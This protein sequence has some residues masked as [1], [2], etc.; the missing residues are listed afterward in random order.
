MDFHFNISYNQETCTIVLTRHDNTTFTIDLPIE[1]TVKNGHYDANT[2][3]LVLVLV[4]NQEIRIPAS[5]LI[6]DYAGV[7]TAT[8]QLTISADNKISANII[9]GSIT[10][11]L[12]TTELQAELNDKVGSE[13]FN[14]E[15]SKKLNTAD[16]EE[17]TYEITYEDGTTETVRSV[18]FK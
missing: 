6:D 9:A 8:I 3:E 13:V 10:K 7:D 2:K 12:L 18:V 15:L 1:N 14:Q 11:T 17:K 16:I 5:G 4:S